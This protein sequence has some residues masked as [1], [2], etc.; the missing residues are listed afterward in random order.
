MIDGKPV[1]FKKTAGTDRD[2]AQKY[3]RDFIVDIMEFCKVRDKLDKIDTE[4]IQDVTYSLP[5]NEVRGA[6]RP[7]LITRTPP[8][9]RSNLIIWAYQRA[10]VLNLINLESTK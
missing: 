6:L 1:V 5:N 8:S 3:G 10:L 2:Y 4:S 7:D 9:P